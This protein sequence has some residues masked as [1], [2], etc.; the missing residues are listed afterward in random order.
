MSD[1]CSSGNTAP[2]KDSCPACTQKNLEVSIAT[3]LQHIN[4]PWLMN[5]KDQGY[6]FCDNPACDVVYFAQD[7]SV[8]NAGDLR[9]IVG[10]KAQTK[11]ALIC[12][13]FGVNSDDALHNS[14][15]KAFVIQQTRLHTCACATRNPSGRCC[16]KDF[17]KQ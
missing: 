5:F 1:C 16:L 17:P 4:K 7:G 6:Y 14:E 9:T 2:K 10:I 3:M 15:A 12:Y 11:D 8:I 13:C